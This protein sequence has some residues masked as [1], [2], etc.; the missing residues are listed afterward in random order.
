MVEFFLRKYVFL[1]FL[2]SDSFHIDRSGP[3][4]G[5]RV[6]VTVRVRVSVG[7]Y[8]IVFQNAFSRITGVTI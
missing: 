1:A 4:V 2:F 3:R 5:V 8:G 6:R 7:C